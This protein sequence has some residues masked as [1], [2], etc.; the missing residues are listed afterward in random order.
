MPECHPTIVSLVFLTEGIVF[1][2]LQEPETVSKWGNIGKYISAL[3]QGWTAAMSA[4]SLVLLF[5][6]LFAPGKFK[7]SSAILIWTLSALCFVA[8][9]YRVWR[10]EHDR[11]NT[12]QAKLIEID[13]AKPLIKLRN[14][15]AFYL[16]LVEQGFTLENGQK[17]V[18][19][20]PFLKVRFINAPPTSHEKAQAI[21]I[22][23]SI[24]YYKLPEN[25]HILNIDGR[26]A[27]TDQPP[28]LH[29]LASRDTLLATDLGIGQSTSVDIAYYD[30]YTSKYY[31][32][33]NDNYKHSFAV[34][35][36]HLLDG[37]QFRADI[38]LR[39]PNVDARFSVVFRAENKTFE[40]ESRST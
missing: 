4:A 40:I 8:A 11:A 28:L 39:G 22:R 20:S 31:A 3:F 38:R 30:T 21:G 26:W 32:W 37:S 12:A 24:D 7:N 19:Q 1:F 36:Q 25:V 27:E 33:N 9:N 29:P 34:R 10:Q 5:L 23:S 15:D 6:P 35:P 13:S 18:Q 17:Y 2:V 16:E 14:P